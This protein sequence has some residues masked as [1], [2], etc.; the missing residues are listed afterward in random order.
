MKTAGGKLVDNQGA[1][2]EVIQEDFQTLRVV[3]AHTDQQHGHEHQERV[4]G[5]TFLEPYHYSTSQSRAIPLRHLLA[6]P[7]YHFKA[8]FVHS[9]QDQE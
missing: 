1:F 5:E 3:A 9:T 4:P 7:C 8:Y 6:L 2:L